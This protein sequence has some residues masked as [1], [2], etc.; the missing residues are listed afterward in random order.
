MTSSCS[1]LNYPFDDFDDSSVLMGERDVR[2][3]EMRRQYVSL[4]S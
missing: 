4:A 3:G 2:L 1:S